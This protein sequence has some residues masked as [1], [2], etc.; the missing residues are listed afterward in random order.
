MK[1]TDRRDAGRQLAA[2]LTEYAGKDTVV[3]TIP[4]GGVV[5]GGEIAEALHAPLGVVLVRKIPHPYH[6]EYA[7]G[8]ITQHGAPIYNQKEMAEVGPAWLQEAEKAAREMLARKR[9]LYFKDAPRPVLKNKTVVLVD[10]GISTGYTME[11]AIQIMREREAAHIILAVP[12]ADP[13]TMIRLRP[14]VDT[15]ITLD[16]PQN[17]LGTVGAHYIDYEEVTDDQVVDILNRMKK[18]HA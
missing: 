9:E 4:K 6:P 15:V 12:T 13:E 16:D 11:A 5:I 10:D 2:Q 3:M 8:A 17:Y 14:Q 7:I 1:F 18:V